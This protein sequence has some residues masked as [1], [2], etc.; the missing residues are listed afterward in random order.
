VTD[1]EEH[2]LVPDGKKV[3]ASTVLLRIRPRGIGLVE[4]PEVFPVDQIGGLEKVGGIALFLGY[5]PA[6]VE[7]SIVGLAFQ[8]DVRIVNDVLGVLGCAFPGDGDD[9]IGRIFFPVNQ[10]LVRALGDADA[11]LDP[12]IDDGRNAFF[13]QERTAAKDPLV[14][15][16]RDKGDGMDPPVQKVDAGGMAPAVPVALDLHDVKEMVPPPPE[17]GPVRIERMAEALWSHKVIPGPVAI[18]L[19][20]GTE[21][22][23]R[24]NK[25]F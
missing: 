19:V 12:K 1:A 13:V 10:V 17:N 24:E 6:A 8:P 2:I 23:C 7:D 25:L 16:P 20:S 15:L 21:L 3:G 9:R 22:A 14:P 5:V 11:R 18:R 4:R